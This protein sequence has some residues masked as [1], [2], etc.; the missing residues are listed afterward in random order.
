MINFEYFGS[1]VTELVELNII[2][3]VI[4]SNL[5]YVF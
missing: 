5:K 2:N 3:I 1:F 4:F